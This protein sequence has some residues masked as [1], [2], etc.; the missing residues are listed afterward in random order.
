M[1]NKKH[2]DKLCEIQEKYITYFEKTKGEG[3]PIYQDII[4]YY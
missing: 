2:T 3:S 1:L 4:S